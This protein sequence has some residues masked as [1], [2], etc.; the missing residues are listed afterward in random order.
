[1][2]AESKMTETGERLLLITNK[3]VPVYVNKKKKEGN[4]IYYKL[5]AEKLK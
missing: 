2:Q 4:L 5:Y 3:R 1:M